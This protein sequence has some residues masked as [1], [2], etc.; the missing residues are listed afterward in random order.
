M[1]G[2]EE[3]RIIRR[4]KHRYL[5]WVTA[6]YMCIYIL[7]YGL[8]VILNFVAEMHPYFRLF[9]MLAFFPASYFITRRI[10]ETDSFNDLICR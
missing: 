5:L 3:E 6:V 1:D 2:K 8:I 9:L 4:R 7:L 10:A